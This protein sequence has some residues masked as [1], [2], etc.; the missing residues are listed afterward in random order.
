MLLAAGLCA[1]AGSRILPAQSVAVYGPGTLNRGDPITPIDLSV[2][3]SYPLTTPVPLTK[4]SVATPDV[5]DIV[6][7]GPHELVING[8][9]A[10]ET[11]AILWLAD[12]TRKHLRVSV[13]PP[14][15]RPQIAVFIKFAEV[16]RDLLRTIGVSARYRDAHGHE[17]VGTGIFNTDNVFGTDGKITIPG[18]AGFLT[19]LTDFNT[20]RLLALLDAEE[21]L[22]HSRTLA[23][24]NVLAGNREEANFLAGG[25][26]PIPVV[27]GG[28]NNIGGNSVTIMYKE[29][30]VRLHFV[31]EIINDSL[32]KLM[33]RPEVSSLD[34]SNAIQLS[35]FSIPAFRTRR[36]ETTLDVRRDQS[37]VISGLFND[38]QE[39]VRT[40]IPF[41][42]SVPIL[43]QLFSSTRWQRNESELIVIVTPIIMDAM[44]P[45]SQ[46]VVQLRPDTALPARDAI[47][48]RLA[49]AATAPTT[50]A[51]TPQRR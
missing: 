40:G 7:V 50:P 38:D 39:R 41:L 13:R 48:Q 12:G 43:G 11:D 25:E 34:Y 30:G 6:V 47:Q 46:N 51:A 10:G 31:P 22:G 17:R 36:V 20:Q 15:D 28:A 42:Q 26:L 44:H 32:I 8:K 37:I 27:Q 24:P 16:R 21:Q 49:P 14:A 9:L 3:R 2:G 35:G 29:F 33:L 4:A 45:L 1:A 23:E 18:T 19:V 5:A